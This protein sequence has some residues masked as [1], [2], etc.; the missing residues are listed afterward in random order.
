MMN[1]SLTTSLIDWHGN[2]FTCIFC[3]ET[4]DKPIN[5]SKHLR[6]HTGEKNTLCCI[7]CSQ[8]FKYEQSFRAYMRK[9]KEK[10]L[11]SE[12]KTQASISC[13]IRTSAGLKK[14]T[15][16]ICD[17]SFKTKSKLAR[18]MRMHTGEIPFKCT[19][20]FAISHLVRNVPF[21]V[22]S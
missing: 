10:T 15:C 1:D 16:S 12:W 2:V 14:H 8:P 5:L 11:K 18:H 3:D 13:H 20:R 6:T 19:V 21:H 7:A 17:K 4:F 9:H 22:I